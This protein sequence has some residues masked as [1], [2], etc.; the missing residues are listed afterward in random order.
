MKETEEMLEFCSE[1][2]IVCQIE[3]IG[4][5][6]INTAYDRV[7]RSDVKYRFVIDCSTI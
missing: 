1:H 4:A 6:D 3:K 2:N 5:N 7:M